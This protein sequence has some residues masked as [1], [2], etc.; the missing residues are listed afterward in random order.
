MDEY[1]ED[2]FFEETMQSQRE[3]LINSPINS[4]ALLSN[5]T[6]I[7]SA[8]NKLSCHVVACDNE[9]RTNHHCRFDFSSVYN[10][11]VYFKILVAIALLCVG[12]CITIQHIRLSALED[13]LKRIELRLVTKEVSW[14]FSAIGNWVNKGHIHCHHSLYTQLLE[15]N[16][17][18]SNCYLI[19]S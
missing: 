7:S 10:C 1:N 15:R 19:C 6:T 13:R 2:F 9:F 12:S 3:C 4:F 17:Q 11:E 8:T 18:L 14:F 16:I 5:K